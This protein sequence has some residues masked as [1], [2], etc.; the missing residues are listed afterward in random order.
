[1]VKDAKPINITLYIA[2]NMLCARRFGDSHRHRT[3]I[4]FSKN[5]VSKTKQIA[6]IHRTN[7]DRLVLLGPFHEAL[8]D[9]GAALGETHL[10]KLRPCRP[11]LQLVEFAIC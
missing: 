9:V 6:N 2:S 4:V 5:I 10:H 11:K 3:Q 7:N 1:M 8:E